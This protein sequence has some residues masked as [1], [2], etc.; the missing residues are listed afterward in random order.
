MKRLF[1]LYHGRFPSE[2]AASLFAAKS[3]E[4]FAKDLEVTLI[5]PRRKGITSER[6]FEY[7][8]IRENFKISYVPTIDL[9]NV[10]ILRHIAFYISFI[11]YSVCAIFLLRRQASNDDIIYSNEALPL[12]LSTFFYK[13]TFYE[14]HDF[15]ENKK[16]F[17]SSL[18]KRVRWVLIT[19]TWKREAVIKQ[20]HIEPNKIIMERNAVDLKDF[21]L[22]ITKESARKKLMLPNEKYIALY[23]GHLYSWKGVDVF[24]QAA[25]LLPENFLC[26]FV[27]GTEQD[28]KTF[29]SK[30]SHCGNIKI[31]GFKP[32]AEIPIW[33][34]AADVLILPNTSHEQISA[35]YTS[36]MKLFEYMASGT[37][38]I[39]SNIPSIAEILSEKNSVLVTPDNP[40]ALTEAIRTTQQKGATHLSQNALQDIREHSWEKRANRIM[41]FIK[42]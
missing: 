6:P 5:V 24:A 15:P 20:F 9:F 21:A 26:I 32:H 29:T 11:C 25:S 35:L 39:A 17:Y 18:L 22:D 31:V 1:L 38:I 42:N 33:Q 37:A 36:P 41:Q 40:Q 7:Y 28:I 8:N 14:L 23:T 30:Y 12:W 10:P 19:N 3:A 34:K 2:K 13:N 16:K 27:G 4:V